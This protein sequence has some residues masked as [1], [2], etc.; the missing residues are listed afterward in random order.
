MT[1]DAMTN[2]ARSGATRRDVLRYAAGAA[3]L[4]LLVRPAAAT[5]AAMQEA[6]RKVVGEADI[7]P[8]R[9][10]LDI[11]P[12]VDNGNAITCTVS[13]DSPMT[14]ENHVRAIHVFNEKNPQPNVIGVQLGPRAGR[15]RVST[16][17][18]IADTQTIVAIAQLSDGTF[19]SDSA[20]V[21]V[22]LGACLED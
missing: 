1:E 3:G 12:L 9:V 5:P 16:R 13:V 4:A 15:A 10:T 21:I 2:R 6:I 11:A 18:R 22:T 19:W 17:I 8:G 7:R 14:R 20:N